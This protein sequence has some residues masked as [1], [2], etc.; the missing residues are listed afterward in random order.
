MKYKDIPI[1]Q[2]LASDSEGEDVEEK[3]ITKYPSKDI[4][5]KLKY[6]QKQKVR[7]KNIL[8]TDDPW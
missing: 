2:F 3:S 5:W 6:N 8:H 7:N 1:Q 4:N